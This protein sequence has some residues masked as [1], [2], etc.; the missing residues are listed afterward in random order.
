MTSPLRWSYPKSYQ[1]LHEMASTIRIFSYE[2]EA[3]VDDSERAKP[4]LLVQRGHQKWVR[5]FDANDL[6][7][8]GPLVRMFFDEVL[9]TIREQSQDAYQEFMHHRE[10]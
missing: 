7:T 5:V 8:A 10:V 4:S 2:Y 9:E 3:R 1:M 6:V